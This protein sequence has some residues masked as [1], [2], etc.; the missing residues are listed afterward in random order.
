VS[1]ILG[2][3][4]RYSCSQIAQFF[5]VDIFLPSKFKNSFA[6]TFFGK[7]NFS[8]AFKIDGNIIQ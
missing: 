3:S 6:G 2:K 4:T 7:I 5:E 1:C 8:D